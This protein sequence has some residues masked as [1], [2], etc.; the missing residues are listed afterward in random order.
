MA[1]TKKKKKSSGGLLILLLVVIAAAVA[2]VF[3]LKGSGDYNVVKDPSD[4]SYQSFVI[5]SGMSTK[6]ISKKLYN[7][8]LIPNATRFQKKAQKLGYDKRFQAGEYQLSPSMSTDEIMETLQHAK[9][10][11]KRFTIPEG[12]YICQVAAKL[13]KDGLI[14]SEEE[15]YK[16]CEDDY[17][18]W[19]V[20]DANI[21]EKDPTGT[22]SARANRLEGYLYP[23]T[24]EVFADATAHDIVDKMLSGFN[25]VFTEEM[26][27]KAEKMGYSVQDIVTIASMIERETMADSER[28][29]VA[30]VIYN[31]LNINMALQIDACIQYCLGEQKDRVLYKDLEIDSK[32]NS[33]KYP[34][35]PIGPIASPGKASLEAALNPDSTNYYYYVLKPDNSG[36]HNFAETLEQFNKYKQQYINSL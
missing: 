11:T 20:S 1:R 27:K 21:R 13:V 22:V 24:Y 9:R 3:F 30:S 33:Y 18:Y 6:S 35:L 8:G 12:Y 10:E 28:A 2:A 7:Q 17:D 16:A 34:G 32:Y 23:N 26:K 4:T 5:E 36:T 25:S 15:F 19:F 14:A 31:R 29:K